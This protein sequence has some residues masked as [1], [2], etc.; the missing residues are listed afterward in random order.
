VLVF[1]AGQGCR[2]TDLDRP[3]DPPLVAASARTSEIDDH[4]F[5]NPELGELSWLDSAEPSQPRAELEAKVLSSATSFRSPQPTPAEAQPTSSERA[6]LGASVSESAAPS[7]EPR[8]LPS[9]TTVLHIGDSFAGALGIAL[10]GELKAAGVH[11]ILHFKVASFIPDWAFGKDVPFYVSSFH[12]DLVLITLGANEVAMFDPTQRAGTI[13]R[14]V[15]R[16]EGRPCVWIAPPLWAAGDRGLLPVIRANCA[17][18]RYMDSNA[19]YPDMPRLPDKIHPSMPARAEWAKRV[20]A[21]LA[22]ER[23]PT[24]GRPWEL[25]EEPA[26]Q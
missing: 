16:L 5:G 24:P 9:G 20:V 18:C 8:P 25:A 3:S 13:R 4:D 7:S 17:P 11:S 1:F 10:N 26:A 22:R 6:S 19:V 2:K 14:L 15:K 12:P 21:W 23:R